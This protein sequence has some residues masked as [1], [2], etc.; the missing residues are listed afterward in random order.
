MS[1][2][3]D[4][5]RSLQETNVR[6][7]EEVLR[8]RSAA[9]VRAANAGGM[10]RRLSQLERTLRD[11]MH[12]RDRGADGEAPVAPEEVIAE[13]SPDVRLV[14][15]VQQAS[16][17]H[18]DA[19]LLLDSAIRSAENSPYE[20]VDRVALILETMAHLARRRQDG[21]LGTSLRDTF[22]EY[23]ID[24]RGGITKATSPRQLDQ[25]RSRMPSGQEIVC[26]E[27]I[28]L[29][30]SY[31]PRHCL[32]IYFT[33]RAPGEPRFVISHVGRHFDVATTT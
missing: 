21:A 24:Y 20:D 11:F 19:L 32:R 13:P 26:E 33:S 9:A 22:R 15:V 28:A 3:S 27:H 1:A 18:G 16:A 12:P 7:I 6:L 14:S 10:E 17:V 29:G 31:D 23:G 8:L 30:N 4:A 25:Y 2:I 5:L